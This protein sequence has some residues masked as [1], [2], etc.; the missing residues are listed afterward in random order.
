M[1]FLKR[2]V[3]LTA[4]QMHVPNR[5]RE[6]RETSAVTN[7]IGHLATR[8]AVVERFLEIADLAIGNPNVPRE[9]RDTSSIVVLDRE[10]KRCFIALQRAT[11][12]AELTVDVSDL[13][14]RTGEPDLVVELVP[15]CG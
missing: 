1:P 12:F 4:R 8:L 10:R 14:G 6:Y 5:L 7:L 9:L 15:H 11:T 2:R 3:M 13:R